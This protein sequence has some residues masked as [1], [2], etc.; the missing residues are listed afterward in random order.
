MRSLLSLLIVLFLSSIAFAQ[1]IP[2]IGNLPTGHRPNS[3]HVFDG[4]AVGVN[5][6]VLGD[7]LKVYYKMPWGEGRSMLTA[8]SHWRVGMNNII[9]PTYVRPAVM[10]GV[11][12]L[13]ILD[14]DLH[15]GPGLNI[16]HYRYHSYTDS[17]DPVTFNGRKSG[18]GY[19]HQLTTNTVLKAG[20]GPI[21]VLEMLDVEYFDAPDYFF[22]WEIGAIIKTGWT[23]RSKTFLLWE[24]EKNWRVFVNYEWFHYYASD[25]QNQLVSVGLLL[26]G[27]LPY[28]ISLLFQEGYHVQNPKFFGYKFWAAVFREW[29]FPLAAKTPAE[30]APTAAAR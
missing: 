6:L 17:F 21:A 16:A 26:A 4:L 29:D 30:R 1:S 3:L 20:V 2:D 12:P 11:S 14:F 24:F 8:D 23:T 5:P 7:Q 10:I 19:F 9:S 13:L 22:D 25:Y 28:H 18:F 27:V 15:Y